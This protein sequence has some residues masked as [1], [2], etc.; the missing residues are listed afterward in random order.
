MWMHLPWLL[1]MDD[2]CRAKFPDATRLLQSV[3]NHP[4]TRKVSPVSARWHEEFGAHGDGYC[5][6]MMWMWPLHRRG[7]SSPQVP[8]LQAG[9]VRG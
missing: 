8:S 3:Y 9:T 6:G 1:V 7:S 5:W 2:E 4:T